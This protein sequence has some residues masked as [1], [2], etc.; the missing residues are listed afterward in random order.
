MSKIFVLWYQMPLALLGLIS[1]LAIWDLFKFYSDKWKFDRYPLIRQVLARI[2]Q[3][4]ELS[5]LPEVAV[6]NERT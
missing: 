3:C 6:F 1:S 5:Y 4:G 2:A